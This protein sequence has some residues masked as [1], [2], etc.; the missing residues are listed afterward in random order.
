[1]PRRYDSDGGGV[2]S[3]VPGQRGRGPKGYLRTDTRIADDLHQRLTDDDDVD[4]SDITVLVHYG[5]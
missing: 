2:L 4:A 3:G 5:E 1:M